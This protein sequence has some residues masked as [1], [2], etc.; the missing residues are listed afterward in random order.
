MHKNH[1]IF[2]PVIALIWLCGV[3]AAGAANSAPVA[4]PDSYTVNEDT[5]LS[6]SSPGVLANDTDAD[7]NSLSALLVTNVTHGT[8]TLNTS[9]SFTY[10]PATNYFG[11]D[12]FVYRA[13]DSSSTSA[14]VLVTL[15]I[16]PTNDAPRATNDSYSVNSDA[17]LDVAEPGVLANDFDVEGETLRAVLV[18]NVTQGTLVLQTNGSFSY[19]PAAG[20]AG[21]DAFTYRAGDGLTTSAVVTATINVIP[22]PIV[23][24]TPPQSQTNCLGGTAV[25]SVTATGTALR[26]QWLKGTATLA[27]QTNNT[28][29]LANLTLTN[30]GSYSVRLIGATNTITNSVTLT[31]NSPVSATPLANLVRFAGSIAIFSTTV[32]GTAPYTYAWTKNGGT[33]PDQTGSSLVLSNLLVTDSGTYSVI[34]SSGCGSVTNSALLTVSTCFSAVDVMLVIDRSG[35]MVGQPYTDAR[36]ACTNFIRTLKFGP[37]NDQAGLASYNPTAT[38]NR[39]LTNSGLALEAAVSALGPATNGTC[40]SCG[41]LTGQNELVSARHRSNS[42]PVIVLMTDGLP[43]DFDSPSNALYNATQVKNAGTRLFTVGLGTGVDSA[44]LSSMAS[45]PGDFFLTTNSAQLADLFEAISTI[46]CRPPTNI[47]GPDDV[48]L[49]AGGSANFTVGASGCETFAYQWRKNGTNLIGETNTTLSLTNL[50]ASDA[51]II[52]VAVTSACRSQTNSAILT[53]NQEVAVTNA[54][55]N[56]TGYVGS[57]VVFSVGATGSGLT[58]QWFFNGQLV[59]TGS[60]LPLNN[61]TTNQYGIYCVVLNALCGGAVTNCA[62][63]TIPNRAPLA[64]PDSYTTPEDTTLIIT[65]PGVLVNDVDLDGDPITSVLVTPPAHGTIT[66][67]TNGSFVYV[68]VANYN[69]ADS[70]TYVATDGSSNSAP[71]AVTLDVTGVNDAPV[72]VN[73]AYT[74]GEDTVLVIAGPGVL[75]NDTDVDGNPLTSVLLSNVTHGVLALNSNGSFTYT[76]NANFNGVDT[77]RYRARDAVLFSGVAVVTI[78]VVS[79]NDVP[80]AINDAYT[81]AEDTALNVP[82]PGVLTNDTDLDGNPLTAILVTPPTHGTLTLSTNGSFLYLP[83]TNYNGGDSFT[84]MANDGTTNSAPATVTLTVTAVNDAPVANPDSYSTPE[85]TT[86]LVNVPGVLVNDTDVDNNPLT[87]IVVTPPIHGT[88]TLN[89]NGSFTYVPVA[90]YFGADSFTY[91]VSDGL[92]NSSPALVTLTMT[93][94]NDAPVANPDS[95]TTAEDTTLIVNVPGV[96]V[97]DTDVENNPLTAVIVTL[98][99]LGTLTLNTN[100]SFIYVPTANSNGADSFTYRVNDGLTSSAP[101]TV[102]LTITS[103]ND[104][105]VANAD[106]YTTAEDTALIVTAPGVLVNDTDVENNPLTAILVTPPTNGSL[107]LNANG[108][109]TYL[110][111]TNYNG[112]DSFT[113]VANDG[114]ANSGLATVTIAVT[115]VN[116]RPVAV[117]DAFTTAEDTAL[118]VPAAGV[119]TND[120]D[121]D[122]NPLIALLLTP[123][124]HGTLTLFTNGSFSYL[125]LTN[126]NGSDSFTYVANDGTTSS[127]PATVTLTITSVNDV[128]VAN[129]DTYTTAEDTTLIVNVPGVLG[130]D[131]DADGNPLTTILVTPPLHGTLILN[132]NGSLTYL[133][134]TNYNGGDSFTYRASDGQTSSAPATVTLAITT[135]NDVP[136][137]NAD[138]YTTPEDTTLVMAAPGV[139]TNDTDADLNP[140]TTILVTLPTHGTLTLNTNGSFTYVPAAN[141]FGADSFTY[142]ASDGQTSSTPA[143]VTLTIT[144]V[145]DVP[146]AVNDAY[147]TA[148]DTTL[149]VAAPGVLGNDTDADLNPLT[150]VLVISPT[151]GALTLNADGSFS[152]VPA[153]NYFGADSFTY[154]AS[155]GL[156]SSAPATVSLTITSVND[157]PTAGNDDGY[158]VLED[159]TLTVA[160]PGVLANDSDLDLTPLTA[161][162]VVGPTNGTVTLNEDGSFIYTP[163]AD[164]FGPDSFTYVANDGATS[165]AP[166]TVSINVVP[167]ND[168]PSFTAGPDLHIN[169]GAPA[170]TLLNWASN[171]RAGPDNE[172]DQALTLSATIL[173]P[174][175]FAVLPSLGTN[176]TLTYTLAAGA[177]GSAQVKL[178][179]R[180]SGGTNNGGVDL[181]LEKSFTIFINTAPIVSIVSPPNGNALLFPA[182]FSVIAQATDLEGPVTNVQFR[183]N[184]AFFTNI[185]TG[186]FYFVMSG[187][188]VGSYAFQ[189]IA[190]DDRGLTATSS[191]VTILV[192][193]NAVVATG[194]A[195]LNRQNGLFEQFV[196]VSNRTTQTWPNGLRISIYNLDTTNKVWNATGTNNGVPYLDRI[197]SIPPGGVVTNVVQYYVP[198]P[199][200]VPDATLVATP[201]PFT[202]PTVIP[203]I[204]RLLPTGA[205]TFAL[206]FPTTAERF[207]FIQQ[208]TDLVQWTSLPN[209]VAGTGG[210]VLSAPITSEGYRFFRLFVVP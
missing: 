41:L 195:V 36:T 150:T 25:F 43:K 88:L 58:Y 27:G 146:V 65:G 167:V 14:P 68:P 18:A 134:N 40:I 91:Q 140:L 17:T 175:L 6:V 96:L 42:L 165:S 202:V 39:Q 118:L 73:D 89:T 7:G 31:V 191:V 110:P 32:S 187:S 5:T 108:S 111:N 196:T 142:R 2:W 15:T 129:P 33:I 34:V 190:T 24:T 82:L 170:Q 172:A 116:D 166:A 179:L 11:G 185:A 153:A 157:V 181:S 154:R 159:Y 4:N 174:E 81:T 29:T 148:E 136:V 8:L 60:T 204:T 101:T 30:A 107:T 192:V 104:A 114:A 121:M 173:N 199:R 1:A 164:Y 163:T 10:R 105:P 210:T 169:R 28:L 19:T 106:S 22:A 99:R 171:F 120:S 208:S 59:G 128:P 72:A 46:I 85:D 147:T 126:Y 189:A 149:V 141:Y 9:G 95:Y 144:S 61:L 38:L 87:A 194:P 177:T 69:G 84:Y 83:A 158:S 64:G 131:T 57:N 35:S 49:C 71:V 56:L 94:V 122:G 180:D 162:V 86:L 80:V 135:V 160:A 143:T 127:V 197:M 123:P 112:G 63:L 155:D 132:T 133:P 103:V 47:F 161:S 51:G 53:V 16:N 145:N 55:V 124:T 137:A 26:Y 37:T 193:T 183:L 119:L 45:S 70:F 76:P 13:R 139:L 93:A 74:T 113:Y 100:G 50:G 200:T 98:P 62:V 52:S 102:T 77:F 168:A 205:R 207:Y 23:V 188:P 97:N 3:A 115:A 138:S 75:L 203:R 78:T 12:S 109:F 209:P 66:L 184:N 151:H 130:N 201:L 152:Y 90:N 206:Q 178:V 186:P 67:S 117:N 48:T 182:T 156:T 20:Y 125:P 198:N 44:L 21:S 176:G 92:T 79:S 54:P